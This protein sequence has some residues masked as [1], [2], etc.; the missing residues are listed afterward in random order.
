MKFFS[1][2]LLLL[3]AL[4]PSQ[5][6]ALS[7]W[8]PETFGEY[9]DNLDALGRPY[10][11]VYGHFANI[12]PLTI[13]DTT[14]E[15]PADFIADGYRS[16]IISASAIFEVVDPRQNPRRYGQLDVLLTRYWASAL[17]PD[18][19][20]PDPEGYKYI[21]FIDLGDPAHGDR[22][23]TLIPDANGTLT[24]TGGN[25]MFSGPFTDVQ[26]RELMHCVFD[27]ACGKADI[28]HLRQMP[29]FRY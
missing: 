9:I 28:A 14:A 17:G 19:D 15:R 10:K 22:I 20:Q 24:E 1:P 21:N 16:K 3:L 5:S 18:N 7:I 12:A 8:V 25:Y 4:L 23:I 26:A 29:Y 27:G 13:Q 2:L 11:I 6:P